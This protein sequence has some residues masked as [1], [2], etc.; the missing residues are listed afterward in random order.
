M[1][2]DRDEEDVFYVFGI[3]PVDMF[4]SQGASGQDSGPPSGI[5][6]KNMPIQLPGRSDPFQDNPAFPR[7]PDPAIWMGDSIWNPRAFSYS[8]TI[9]WSPREKVYWAY[10]SDRRRFFQGP[11][12]RILRTE[13][14]PSS[15]GTEESGGPD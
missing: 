1:S 3:F 12:L 15:S 8:N 7:R 6:R 13:L 14:N 2:Q 5:E 10:D 9:F 4:Q 11:D